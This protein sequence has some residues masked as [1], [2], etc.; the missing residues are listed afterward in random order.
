MVLTGE[1]VDSYDGHDRWGRPQLTLAQFARHLD[2]PLHFDHLDQHG[3]VRGCELALEWGMAAVT[4]RP[5]HVRQAAAELSGSEVAVATGL[6]FHL[7]STARPSVQDLLDEASLL[8]ARGA[9]ELAVAANAARL[10]IRDTGGTESF[11]SA[12]ATLAEHQSDQGFRVRVH[13]DPTGL[14]HEQLTRVCTGLA[15]A[16]VWMVQAGSWQGPSACYRKLLSIRDALGAGPLLKWTTPVSSFHVI[17]LAMG[18]G[19]NRF[20]ADA[21]TPLMRQAKRQ[22]Q[23]APLALPVP[24]L[25]F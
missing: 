20:N 14:R 16:R 8:V 22:A 4:C 5:E 19:I 1:L 9:T 7:P 24:G 15:D 13:I 11:L 10:D 25:D 3:V 17:L 21:A 23:L 12:L 18:S 2:L 6:G